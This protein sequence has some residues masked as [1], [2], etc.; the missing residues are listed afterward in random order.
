MQMKPNLKPHLAGLGLFLGCLLSAPSY[1]EIHRD[2]VPVVKSLADQ[3][4]DAA[5][6]VRHH[7]DR[8]ASGFDGR[9]YRMLRSLDR[10]QRSA[11]RFDRLMDSYFDNRVE[12]EAELHDLNRDA[13]RIQ[14]T[15]YHSPAMIPAVRDWERAERML[16]QINRYVY[17]E[18]G[19][20]RYEGERRRIGREFE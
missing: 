17:P 18:P 2:D 16:A 12:A 8:Q 7:A 5:H 6:N 1:A 11:V 4:E 14:N 15:L 9:E 20:G 13:E 3:L 10:F 19:D